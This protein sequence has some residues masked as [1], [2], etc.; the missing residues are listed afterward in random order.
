MKLKEIR[1]LL[2]F[3]QIKMTVVFS[4]ERKPLILHRQTEHWLRSHISRSIFISQSVGRSLFCI[5]ERAFAM[6]YGN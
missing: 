3:E 6:Q 4:I 2:V 1:D 5:A